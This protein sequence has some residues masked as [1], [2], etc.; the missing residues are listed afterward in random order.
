MR[1]IHL[2]RRLLLEAETRLPDGAGG[3]TAVWTALGSVWAMIEAGAGREVVALDRRAPK[4][5]L[6]IILRAAPVGSPERPVA[7]QRLREGARRFRILA[8][9]ERDLR[10]LYLTC[11]A[12]EEDD[13]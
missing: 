4:V 9:A 6:T 1:R 8:V 2:N 10:G 3:F 12:E 11:H 5:P 13:A 7:G